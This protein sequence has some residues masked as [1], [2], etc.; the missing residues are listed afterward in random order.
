MAFRKYQ[1]VEDS[2]LVE[3]REAQRI[4]AE[5]HRRG[6]TSA[7]ELTDAERKSA[8]DSKSA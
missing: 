2:R 4:A 8:L 6:K 7:R 3:E 5:L 1:K